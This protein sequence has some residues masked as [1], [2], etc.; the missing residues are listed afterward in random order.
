MPASRIFF[1]FHSV[2]QIRYLCSLWEQGTVGIERRLGFFYLL[3]MNWVK[4]KGMWTEIAA[5]LLKFYE[6]RCDKI[7]YSNSRK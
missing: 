7:L 3:V 4:M 2:I 6:D 5:I 1:F